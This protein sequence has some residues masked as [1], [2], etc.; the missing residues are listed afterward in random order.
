M[1]KR[2][3]DEYRLSLE[4]ALKRGDSTEHTHRPALK[5]LLESLYPGTTATNEPERRP[6]VGAVD[7]TISQREGTVGFIETKDI[8]EP[9]HRWDKSDQGKRYLKAWPSLI[10]TDYLEFRWFR[11]GKLAR[12]ERLGSV[13]G[14][15]KIV[16]DHEGGA[17]VRA[18][19]EEFFAF[20]A[21]P[22]ATA[23]GLAE[24]LAALAHRAQARG[25]EGA[26]PRPA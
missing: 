8:D 14:N 11:D 23:R 5:K 4:K 19:L 15:N 3:F 1:A 26:A 12:K 9:L 25:Q 20:K 10:L 17:K 24:R 16:V 13:A 6:G 7:M 22:P 2:P 21:E 18:L